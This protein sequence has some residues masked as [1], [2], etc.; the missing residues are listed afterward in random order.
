MYCE[1]ILAISFLPLS[2]ILQPKALLFTYCFLCKRESITLKLLSF[3][4]N[5]ESDCNNLLKVIVFLPL[6]NMAKIKCVTLF[7][8]IPI[9]VILTYLDG[10]QQVYTRSSHCIISKITSKISQTQKPGILSAGFASFMRKNQ[11][12]RPNTASNSK[13]LA[14][15]P[16]QIQPLFFI[17]RQQEGM[18]LKRVRLFSVLKTIRSFLTLFLFFSAS[19]SL[20][21]PSVLVAFKTLMRPARNKNTPSAKIETS[22]IIRTLL[23]D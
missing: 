16:V 14:P 18:P 23:L 12:K 17:S 8:C 9:L 6:I 10:R 20:Y 2:V 13:V 21:W 3:T 1:P 5:K 15:M 4:L 22:L 11:K 7:C 19:Q